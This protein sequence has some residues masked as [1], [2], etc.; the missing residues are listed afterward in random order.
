MGIPVLRY[1]GGKGLHADDVVPMEEPLEISIDG[2]PY[3]V[4][5]R[6]PG[7]EMQLSIGFCFTSGI[8]DSMADVISVNY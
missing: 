3:Y 1:A 4:T 2:A 5:M 8:I 7:E 6:L